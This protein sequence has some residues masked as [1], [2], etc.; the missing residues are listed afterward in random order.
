VFLGRAYTTKAFFGALP[1]GEINAWDGT[2]TRTHLPAR[3]SRMK[4]DPVQAALRSLA[5][6]ARRPADPAMIALVRDALSHRSHHVVARAARA[7]REANLAT[8]AEDLVGAFPRYLDDP[9][10]RDPGCVAKTQIVEALLTFQYPAP[11]VYLRG[12]RHVQREPAF[13]KPIDTAADLRGVSALALVVSEH[14]QALAVCVDL[15]VD[16]ESAARAGAARALGASAR[17]DVAL[18]LR[19]FALR[20]D[21]DPGVLAEAFASL[22]ALA[23]AD[24]V[25]FVAERLAATND[26][27]ARAAAFALGETRRADAVAALRTHLANESRPAVRQASILALATSRQDEAF[28]VLLD[29]LTRGSDTDSA[30]AAE[31]FRLYAHDESLQQ[32]VR[33]ALARRRTRRPTRR[34]VR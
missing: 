3:N 12:A 15:L 7:A 19:L 10:R 4:A 8:L 23:P 1:P 25:P 16:P 31:A 32:R 5:E 30:G 2:R 18:T 27:A 20:G 14:P 24:G 33:A 11:D 13:G 34:R 26:D 28:Q 21:R 9:I 6:A 22:M 29:L 17:P